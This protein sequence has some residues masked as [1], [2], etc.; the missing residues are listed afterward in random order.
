LSDEHDRS[1]QQSIQHEWPRAPPFLMLKWGGWSKQPSVA[2][3]VHGIRPRMA[4][5]KFDWPKWCTYLE[6]RRGEGEGE[7]ALG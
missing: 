4:A 6:T 2:T 5:L 1:D 3:P 7:N